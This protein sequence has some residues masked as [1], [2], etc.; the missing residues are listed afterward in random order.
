MTATIINAA[1]MTIELGAQDL[2]TRPPVVVPEVR[3]THLPK[4]YSYMQ[5]GPLDAQLVVGDAMTNIY[6]ANSFDLKQQWATHATVL[7][8]EV[9]KQGNSMMLQ[10]LQPLDAPGPATIRISLDVVPATLTVYA[11]N[12]DG[13]IQL[14]G[15]G[16][17]VPAQPS[18]SAAGYKA[19]WVATVIPT[20]EDGSSEFKQGEIAQG[21]QVV[22]ATT[23][24]R[25]P[26]FDFQV[27]SFGAWGNNQS[28]RIWAPTTES[29]NPINPALLAQGIYP[30]RMACYSRASSIATPTN[31]NTL[32]GGQFVDCCLVPGA[33]SLATGGQVYAGTQFIPSYTSAN[34]PGQPPTFGPFGDFY[35]YDDNVATLVTEFYNHELPYANGFSDFT[36]A[37]GEE[38]L[39]NML[40]GTTSGNV[41]YTSYQIVTGAENSI[42]MSPNTSIYALGGGDGT[43][44]EAL[45]ADLVTTA[46]AAYADPN[47]PVQDRIQNPESIFYDTGF[48]MATKQALAQFISVRKDLALVYACHDVLGAELTAAEEA[49]VALTLLTYVQMYPESDYFG[50]ETMRAAIFGRSG[51]CIA[52]TEYTKPLPLTIEV[53]SKAAQYMGAGNSSWKNGFGFDIAPQNV[54]QLFTNINITFVPASVRNVNWA[55]GLN[56]VES[57]QRDTFFFPAMKTV[58]GNDTS[59]FTS[60]ITMLAKCEL[61]KVGFYA[62][63]NFTGESFLTNS[64]LVDRLNN[65]VTNNVNGRFDN[66]FTITPDAFYTAADDQRGYSWTLPIK[67][68]ADNMK[69]VQTVYIQGYRAS[70]LTATTS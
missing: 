39:F 64:Q 38:Y 5:Q 19:K 27:S 33:I 41:P 40:G 16:N 4:I 30:I 57:F 35:I 3:P 63:Q 29:T 44:N 47:D 61:E 25:Y 65:F 18:A 28:V 9:N 13:S 48:P 59:I 23:S 11:R 51:E 34:T 43:M 69:T 45:F 7:I 52:Y 62:W 42:V 70:D 24:T 50:T 32:S 20:A 54:V 46:V 10:R 67:L 15:S 53:A 14:D 21:D 58:Y 49:S 1:P 66:R 56:W 2:S 68:Y 12:S 60:F 26:I 17:P 55:N 8:N 31:V 37:A 22:N 36:G 6:N